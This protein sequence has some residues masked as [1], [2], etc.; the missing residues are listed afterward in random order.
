NTRAKKKACDIDELFN[1]WVEEAASLG[2]SQCNIE[3]LRQRSFGMHINDEELCE[4]P[5]L[6]VNYLAKNLVQKTSTFSEPQAFK[7]AV[8]LA[9]K[10]GQSVNVALNAVDKLLC[11]NLV[12]ELESHSRYKR[13][14]TTKA[15]LKKEYEMIRG[16][17]TLSESKSKDEFGLKEL[18]VAEARCGITLSDEQREAVLT[19]ID[20]SKLSVIAGSS[21]SGKTTLQN[22]IRHI[23]MSN[24]RKVY[25]AA[26]SKL[27]AKNLQSEASIP[28]QTIAKLLLSLESGTSSVEFGDVLIIDEAGLVGLDDASNLIKHANRIGFK[29]ILAGDHRQ[30]RAIEHSGTFHLLKK[31]ES[32]SSASVSKIIRQTKAW[33]RKAVMQLRDGNAGQALA[34]YRLHNRLTIADTQQQACS[35]L[36][37]DW[38]QYTS[39]NPH[40]IPL[41]IA[42]TWQD[43]TT[44]NEEIRTVL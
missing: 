32:I 30:L 35:S 8:E 18:S 20:N 12:V 41:I 28:S 11:S 5:E 25:G 23:Y 9:R 24:G 33:D 1:R 31:L 40:A 19:A 6:T 17:Q 7:F 22:I 15:I 38:E 4:F 37:K 34:Q 44:L 13:E 26:I 36:V 42:R 16:A 43:V 39:Q 3:K 21:G 27:A 2:F 29:L 14:F 10:S